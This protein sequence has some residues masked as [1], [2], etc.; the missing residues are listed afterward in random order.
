MFAQSCWVTFE[1]NPNICKNAYRFYWLD[2]YFY[3][4]ISGSRKRI[5]QPS[6]PRPRDIISSQWKPGPLVLH[7]FALVL[8]LEHIES[9]S[10]DLFWAG[11]AV[12]GIS[13]SAQVAR[14]CFPTGRQVSD[15]CGCMKWVLIVGPSTGHWDV[16]LIFAFPGLLPVELLT[17]LGKFQFWMANLVENHRSYDTWQIPRI[18]VLW[19]LRNI[20]KLSNKGIAIICFKWLNS[21]CHIFCFFSGSNLFIPLLVKRLL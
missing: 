16:I 3:G 12:I 9:L 19:T 5:R 6:F 14:V 8:V 4:G 11:D 18:S 15:H 10:F 13:P 2:M 21:N 17:S 7:P 1:D 20:F